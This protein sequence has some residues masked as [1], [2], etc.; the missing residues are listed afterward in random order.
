MPLEGT[1]R[2]SR[3]FDRKPLQYL[4]PS[5]FTGIARSLATVAFAAVN[6]CSPEDRIF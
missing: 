3:L 1:R 4:L 5:V 2:S 6:L